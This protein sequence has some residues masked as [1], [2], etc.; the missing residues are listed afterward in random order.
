MSTPDEPTSPDSLPTEA[1]IKDLLLRARN[2][3]QLSLRGVEAE[4]GK[5]RNIVWGWEST[6]EKG[7]SVDQIRYLVWLAQHNEAARFV[8]LRA[9]TVPMGDMERG[10]SETI[11]T[12]RE[13]EKK[14]GESE[15]I[16][17]LLSA[18]RLAMREHDAASA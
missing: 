4:S 12:I 18:L 5:H 9:M 17:S 11:R 3:A 10:D 15:L 6:S 16:R 1:E 7:T 2:A 13:A 14:Y 8:I